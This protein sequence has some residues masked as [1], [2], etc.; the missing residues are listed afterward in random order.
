M[1]RA[2]FSETKT[3]HL[4]VL[5]QLVVAYL[6]PASPW[7]PYEPQ[8][9]AR[10]TAVVHLPT[11]VEANE[12]RRSRGLLSLQKRVS[13]TQQLIA[14]EEFRPSRINVSIRKGK[15]VGAAINIEVAGGIFDGARVNYSAAI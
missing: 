3:S 14:N 1:L 8:H 11:F 12:G 2:S 6:R 4:R 5:E 15:A 9:P 13:L 10:I 7:G